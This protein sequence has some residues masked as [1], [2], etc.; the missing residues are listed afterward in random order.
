M[1]VTQAAARLAKF[2]ATALLALATVIAVA[3]PSQAASGWYWQGAVNMNTYYGA[4]SGN[5]YIAS[6]NSWV[7]VGSYIKDTRTDGYCAAV[8]M[9]GVYSN[10][11]RTN[12]FA[13]GNNCSTTQWSWAQRTLYAA[14]GYQFTNAETR[15][16]QSNRYGSVIGTCSAAVAATSW[17]RV[18][19]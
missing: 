5:A 19:Y 16:C 1:N 12:W 14:P 17:R 2:A 4:A 10:G 13:V 9:R 8:Q 3:L 11:A 18:Y 7:E 6:N 15:T